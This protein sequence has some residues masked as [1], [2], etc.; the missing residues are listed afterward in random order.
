L[1]VQVGTEG[2]KDPVRARVVI[3]NP[4]SHFSANCNLWE[5]GTSEIEEK[6][7]EGVKIKEKKKL[8][9]TFFFFEKHISFPSI[10]FFKSILFATKWEPEG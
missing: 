1:K 3:I 2:T 9:D 10:Y 5:K 6:K 7:R 4:I 8:F